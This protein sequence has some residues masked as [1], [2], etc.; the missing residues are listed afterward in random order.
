MKVYK[1]RSDIENFLEGDREW[2]EG[3]GAG[4]Q[5]AIASFSASFS[6]WDLSGPEYKLD[7]PEAVS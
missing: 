4:D 1:D 5:K 2:V 7:G 6:R 3:V